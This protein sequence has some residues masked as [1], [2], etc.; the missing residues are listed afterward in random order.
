MPSLGDDIGAANLPDR[1]RAVGVLEQDVVVAG[2]VVAADADD[3]GGAHLS[4]DDQLAV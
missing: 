4:V 3:P 1:D 2:A